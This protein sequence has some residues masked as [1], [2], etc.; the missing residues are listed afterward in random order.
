MCVSDGGIGAW[1]HA[2]SMSTKP[3]SE[4]RRK[5]ASDSRSY[6]AGWNFPDQ[7]NSIR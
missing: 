1:P 6:L 3:A 7:Y 4:M 5:M 2:P